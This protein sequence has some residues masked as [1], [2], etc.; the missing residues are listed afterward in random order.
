MFRSLFLTLTAWLLLHGA[1]MAQIQFCGETLPQDLPD[2][3]QRWERALSRQVA[4]SAQV[5]RLKQRGAV[6]FPVIEPMLE[7]Y[8]IPKDFK[9]IPLIESVLHPY[10]SFYGDAAGFWQLTPQQGKRLGLMVAGRG[11]DQRYDLRKS[12]V[13]VC[14]YLW[15]LHR[16][17]GSWVLVAAAYHNG[18]QGIR[19]VRDE[20]KYPSP[21]SV[22]YHPETRSALYQAIVLKELFTHPTAYANRVDDT[23]RQAINA[24]QPDLTASEQQVIMASLTTQ[25]EPT[26]PEPTPEPAQKADI[27]VL[28][29]EATA[30]AKTAKLRQTPTPE[31]VATIAPTLLVESRGVTGN[32]LAEGQ[33][34]LFEVV[35]SQTING[36]AVSVGDLIYAH[37]ETVDAATGRVFLRADRLL[38]AQTQAT[39]KLNMVAVEKSKQPGVPIPARNQIGAGWRL[40]W[41]SL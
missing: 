4:Q 2:V 18:P 13:A 20:Q 5:V 24:R 33:L 40:S 37:I 23:A 31:M 29:E 11:K 14:E 34:V 26:Q 28:T 36:L 17:L 30:P 1:S 39:I 8:A 22:A 35:R 27:V 25:P 15:Q 38:L 12:T 19:Q 10:P 16:E 9:Y 3:R 32:T 21:F 41:E 6:V 7:R